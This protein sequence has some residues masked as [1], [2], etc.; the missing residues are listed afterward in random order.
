VSYPVPQGESQRLSALRACGVLDTPAHPAFDALTRLAGRVCDAPI[1]AVVLVDKDR[2]W[3]KSMVGLEGK[4]TSREVSFCAHAIVSSKPLVVRDARQ[5]SRFAF[6]PLV[7]GGPRL[8]SYA[9]VPLVLEGEHAVG[10]ICVL[11]TRPRDFTREQLEALQ[12]LAAQAVEHLLH[13]RAARELE[14]IDAELAQVRH[15]LSAVLDASCVGMFLANANGEAYYF[16]RAWEKLAGMTAAE[17]RQGGWAPR[18]HA[19]DRDKIVDGWIGAVADRKPFLCNARFVHA[20]GKVVHVDASCQPFFE[21]NRLIGYVGTVIDVSAQRVAEGAMQLLIS[22]HES[23]RALLDAHRREVEQLVLSMA[24]DLQSPLAAIG[25]QLGV[26]QQLSAR[27]QDPGLAIAK[28]R[29]GVDNLAGMLDGLMGY[30]RA[31]REQL[32]CAPMNVSELVE[33]VVAEL[34][35]SAEAKGVALVVEASPALASVNAVAMRRCVQNLVSNAVKFTP[36]GGSVRV[37]CGTE[38]ER[39]RLI[40]EDT[41]PGLPESMLVSVFDPFTRGDAVA[42]GTGLGLATVKRYVEAFGGAVWLETRAEGGL[43]AV[44]ILPPAAESDSARPTATLAVT[45]GGPTRRAA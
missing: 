21:G 6:N 40:V 39:V 42:P 10:T 41:G 33:D 13:A 18:L 28:A 29:A 19:Q 30:A 4:Q 25:G 26:A 45:H 7:T 3:F 5:D 36:A 1:A 43:R 23:A 37:A 12:L 22:E 2:Q 11:D 24:H 35:A 15:Q 38:G 17:A 44:A 20:D 14:G 27:S 16:N 9:G 31:G 32:A 34:A 8:R